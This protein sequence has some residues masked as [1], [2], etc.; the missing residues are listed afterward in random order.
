MAP[1]FIT[2]HGD[3]CYSNQ[4]RYENAGLD[5]GQAVAIYV[6]TYIPPYSAEVRDNLK[7][8]VDPVVWV[9]NNK[10]RFL[11]A[12]L[13]AET[14]LDVQNCPCC[15]GKSEATIGEHSFQ[16]VKVRCNECG[17][18]TALADEHGDDHSALIKN[19]EDAVTWWNKR[20]PHPSENGFVALKGEWTKQHGECTKSGDFIS[21]RIWSKCLQSLTLVLTT[22]DKP[23]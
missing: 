5:F 16:D 20:A 4:D 2:A 1:G 14:N 19:F 21:A 8:Y 7:V 13:S 17:L 3:K 18:E 10:H 12:L 6:L 22:P 15:N 11:P 23:V 9:I